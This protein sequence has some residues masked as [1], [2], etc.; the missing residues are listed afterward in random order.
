MGTTAD[1]RHPITSDN[2]VGSRIGGEPQW[3]EGG[4]AFSRR[5]D[6]QYDVNVWGYP[7]A[8][9]PVANW[10]SG[11]IIR[12]Y[13]PLLHPSPLGLFAYDPTDPMT[14]HQPQH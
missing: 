8:S 9:N 14:W 3:P 2:Q 5:L 13:Q 4:F 1:P 12:K 6:Y 10:T 11:S 7:V